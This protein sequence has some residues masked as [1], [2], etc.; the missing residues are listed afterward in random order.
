MQTAPAAHATSAIAHSSQA[1]S[2]VRPRNPALFVMRSL[3][4][5]LD[6]DRRR[7]LIHMPIV[8]ISETSDLL[9]PLLLGVMIS[10][11]LAYKPGQSVLP[12]CLVITALAAS[13]GLTAWV[14]L[15]SKRI[16]GQ[17]ALNC[18]YRARVWGFER[19]VGFSMHWHHQESAGN[20]V[21]RLMTGS[22]AV[23]E[24]G[25][26]H[27]D[28][29]GPLATLIG[30]TVSC[31]FISPWFIFFGVYFMLGMAYIERHYD[32]KVAALST[33]INQSVE[34]ASGSIVEGATHIL[35][36]KASGA[37]NMVRNA[38]AGRE[39]SARDLGHERVR[40]GTQKWLAFQLHTCVA[41]GI[42]LGA[43]AWA[44]LHDIIA[45]SFI[46]T[47]VQYFNGLRQS[48][49]SFTDRFQAMVERYADLMRLMP[50]FDDAGH[51]GTSKRQ[52][53]FP[54]EWD[55]IHISGLDYDWGD[56]PALRDINLSL[57][58]GERIGVVGQS[59]SGKSTLIKLL[60]GLY[61]P[62][63]GHIRIGTVDS[64]EIDAEQFGQHVAVVLQEVELFNVTLRDNITLMRESDEAL[65]ARVC[66]AAGLDE[67]VARLPQGVH[68]P[69]G[70]RGHALSGGE[71]QRIGIA[72]ALFRRPDILILD[73]ATS[74]L[75][76]DTE[77]RVMHGILQCVPADAIVIAI[78][79][80]TR[81]LKDMHR[82]LRMEQGRLQDSAGAV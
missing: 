46:I 33:R 40:L 64:R 10:M 14:R 81:S 45:A 79:H 11:L 3:F 73:E 4:F 49:T 38:V 28:V 62:A 1:D 8:L 67:L 39:A 65:F 9:P 20:K 16:L 50:L 23:R 69:L 29:A 75:D 30:V 42:F 51:T 31:A 6:S 43:I 74:A 2:A 53:H 19:L 60:L 72:R 76:D 48:T 24:W 17:I 27:N 36:I 63:R 35:T 12:L 71:R 57:R 78:A 59:G 52:A 66:S 41:F 13:R 54:T 77:D 82:L 47:Y 70:E 25:I 80:R 56:K 22:D 34:N 21:Q 18:R 61:D 68:T 55:G 32:R 26:F 15:R 58:R 37:G 7:Y 5:F 44:T